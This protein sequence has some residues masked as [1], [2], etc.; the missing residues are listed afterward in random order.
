MQEIHCSLQS[1]H[2][3]RNEYFSCISWITGLGSANYLLLWTIILH[4]KLS[5]TPLAHPQPSKFQPWRLHRHAK[6]QIYAVSR[7]QTYDDAT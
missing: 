3:L 1:R 2:L 7:M 4:L 5:D 6:P